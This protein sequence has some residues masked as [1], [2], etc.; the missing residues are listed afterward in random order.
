MID[1]SSGWTLSP[2]YDLLNVSILLPEDTEELALTLGGKKKKLKLD[3][4]LTLG[5]G[6]GLTTKQIEGTF[7]RFKKHFP[8]AFQCLE[9]SFLSEDMKCLYKEIIA[10]RRGRL[11]I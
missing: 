9:R 7:K 8:S 2:A 10:E 4:F 3:D 11:A 1:T 5:E 6:L